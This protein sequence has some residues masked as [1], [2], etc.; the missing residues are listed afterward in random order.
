MK[1]IGV[2]GAGRMGHL[3]IANAAANPRLD[4]AYVADKDIGRATELANRYG[5]RACSVE[6]LIQDPAVQ[7]VIVATSSDA[8]L[9]VTLSARRAG[10]SVFVEKPLSLSLE[11]LRQTAAEFAGPG[12]AVFVAFNR[13]FDPGFATLRSR[14]RAGEIGAL[15]SLHIVNHDPAPPAASFI[16]RS[17]GLFRDFTIHDFDTAAWLLDEPIA[18][19]FAWATCLIDPAIAAFGDVDT[20]KLILKTKTG[21]LC[22][23]SNSRRTGYGYDQRIEAF[24]ARGALRAENLHRDTVSLWNDAGAA[25]APIHYA[26]PDRYAEAYRLEMDHFADILTS[27]ERPRTGPADAISALRLAE[28]AG[29]ALASGQAARLLAGE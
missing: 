2:V 3:H 4:F 26:F 6:A 29:R 16:P 24:G 8:A 14:L 17:G 13:R 28:A 15:E 1:R 19:V 20:A 12:P 11:T 23:I 7:G 21:R 18:E 9:D 5:A 10:K 22:L 25:G 27:G